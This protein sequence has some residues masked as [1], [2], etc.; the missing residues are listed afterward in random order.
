[1]SKTIQTVW[2]I[3]DDEIYKYGFR[4]YISIK[5]ICRNVFEFNNGREAI[6]YLKDPLNNT[7]LPDIIFL[8]IDMPILDGWGFVNEFSELK[9]QIDKPITLLMVTSSLNYND[10]VRARSYPE[11]T[12]YIVKPINMREF[13]A[14][15]NFGLE[16]KSA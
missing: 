10:I 15:F 14:A 7:Q 6:N 12:D 11:V 3:D 16:K 13:S 1:M 8:D 4:K 9:S 5:K 2:I